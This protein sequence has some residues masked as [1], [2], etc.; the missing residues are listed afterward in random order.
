MYKALYRKW[1]PSRFSEVFGQDDVTSILRYQVANNRHSHAYL[2]CGSRGTG[3]TSCAKILAKA[4]NCLAP[5][6]GEPC[7]KC[8]ACRSI[9]EGRSL[10]VIEMDAASNNGVNDIRD[11]RDEVVYTPSALKYKV[12]IVDEVHM[13]SNEAFNA[14]L[15]T[16]EEPPEYVVFILATTEM[17]QIPATIVSRC[18]RFDFH[19]IP[20]R[21]LAE[22]LKRIAGAENAVLTDDGAVVLAR[23]ANGGARDAISL[24][25]ICIG[26][27]REINEA[28]VAETLGLCGSETVARLVTAVRD[29]DIPTVFDI[30]T[31]A[32][33]SSK[34]IV[35]FWQ[36]I[37]AWYRDM[38]VYKTVN[39]PARYLTMT[40]SEFELLRSSAEPFDLSAILYHAKLLDS[41]LLLMQKG[42]GNK[43][44]I[45]ELTL[46]RMSEPSL[47]DESEALAARVAELENKLLRL[48]AAAPAAAGKEPESPRKERVASP[49]PARAEEKKPSEPAP[50]PPEKAAPVLWWNEAKEKIG[51][52]ALS[53]KSYVASSEVRET[54]A[55][56]EIL[57]RSR[58]AKIML[59]REDTFSMVCDVV[60]V[61][62]GTDKPV[63]V[64]VAPEKNEPVKDD[65]TFSL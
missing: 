4:L 60:R 9:D 12:Y 57:V 39:D 17:D 27:R 30:M 28:L 49:S 35:V 33:A 2:F 64:S 36:D 1:R 58:I 63:S 40:K 14:L 62:S 46:V 51:A 32:E 44:N 29:R 56:I 25:E 38:L 13:L 19:R 7:G 24:L 15:K 3:K 31:E 52:M 8:E 11:I 53:V 5:E 34:D 65:G 61:C 22:Q 54:D 55:G 50:P 41:A 26:K 37:I 59:E 6:D 10:D 21:L 18:Q 47:S 48:S 43:R 23:L 16:L 45:A 20:A 42:A